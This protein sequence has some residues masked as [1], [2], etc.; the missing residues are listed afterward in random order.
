MNKLISDAYHFLKKGGFEYNICGGFALEMFANKNL[1]TH[2]DLD[3]AVFEEDKI[4]AISF[5]FEQGWDIFARFMEDGQLATQMLFYK[6]ENPRDAQWKGCKNF[7][8]MKPT[9]YLEMYELGRHPGT[10]SYRLNPDSDVK[11]VDAFDFVEIEIDD[12]IEG[13]Y[14]VKNELK[15]SRAMEKAIHC[16]DG[17]PY[18]APEIIL[19]LKSDQRSIEHPSTKD[20]NVT[21]FKNIYPL[22]CDEQKSWLAD[23]LEITYPTGYPWLD[24]WV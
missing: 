6:V 19:Y 24:G 10:Y 9:A 17:I 23:A 1:R 2:G 22:L 20:K 18:L 7:W 16:R 3:I 4:E 13:E 8:A 11:Y 21:D 14:V 15:I 12:K 5:L